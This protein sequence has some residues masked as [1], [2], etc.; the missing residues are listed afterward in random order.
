MTELIHPGAHLIMPDGDGDAVAA[1]DD[2][3]EVPAVADLLAD[4]GAPVPGAG[5]VA[6]VFVPEQVVVMGDR[7]DDAAH[8]CGLFSG[9]PASA[10]L[11]AVVGPARPAVAVREVA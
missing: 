3:F 10:D 7:V 4:V 2:F 6:V 8:A 11:L 1:G 9:A 5:V